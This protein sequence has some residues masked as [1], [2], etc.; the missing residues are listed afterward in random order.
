ME[1]DRE[2]NVVILKEAGRSLREVT[3]TLQE[4]MGIG[5]RED[6]GLSHGIL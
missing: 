1:S 4:W 5:R 2:A 6:L 3:L